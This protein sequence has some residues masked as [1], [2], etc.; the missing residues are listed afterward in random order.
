MQKIDTAIQGVW[1]LEPVVFQDHR[2]IFFE[3]YNQDVFR[4]LGIHDLFVQDNHSS[5]VEGVLRGLHFQYPPYGMSK[6]VRCTRGQ[7][8]DVVVDLRQ[9]SPSYKKWVGVEL[10][11]ENRRLLYIPTG[12]AHGFFALSHCEL[13]YKCGNVFHKPA[14]G[15]VA[16]DD[17]EIGIE[18]PLGNREPI[19]SDRDRTQPSFAEVVS[20]ARFE[21]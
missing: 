1:I 7:L 20:R 15:G 12:C 3:S 18:W 11:E 9:D 10:N 17:P 21:L 6:L 13:L 8:F 14:D 16:Y 5:S 2:G 4:E 19:L